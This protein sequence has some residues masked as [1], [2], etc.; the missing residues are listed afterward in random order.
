MMV[1]QLNEHLLNIDIV[2][3]IL[4]ADLEYN[5]QC[6]DCIMILGSLKAT[7]YRVPVGVSLYKEGRSSKILLSGGKPRP[8]FNNI[9]ECYLMQDEAIKLGIP[10]SD[11]IVEDTSLTTK[12]NIICSLL[13][14]DR[15]F[16]LSNIKSIILVTTA[17]HMRRSILMAKTYS[18]NWINFIPCPASDTHTRRNNWYKSEK[19]FYNAKNEVL[20]IISYINEGSIPDFEI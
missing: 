15:Y 9:K 11:I 19:G 14:L 4:F 10:K 12:E 2:D 3:R 18:P 7:K 17:Y 6:A 8:E 5:N 1:S 16:K 13:P 20:K